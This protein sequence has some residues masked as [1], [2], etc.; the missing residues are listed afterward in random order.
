MAKGRQAKRDTREGWERLADTRPDIAAFLAL[1]KEAQ[2]QF[3]VY[4][5]HER[6][7]PAGA[8]YA[9]GVQRRCGCKPYEVHIIPMEKIIK[10]VQETE[11][12]SRR[13]GDSSGHGD[14]ES[15]ERLE[16]VR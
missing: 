7:C 11:A 16:S 2:K 4:I 6:Y 13:E 14:A 15:P 3:A 5:M 9:D 8:H 10:D 12:N 1:D